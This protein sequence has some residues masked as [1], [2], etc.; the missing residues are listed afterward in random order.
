MSRAWNEAIQEFA[1]MTAAISAEALARA[2][3]LSEA[4]RK[5]MLAH[6]AEAEK[7]ARTPDQQALVF[8]LRRI[9]DAPVR[10]SASLL[11]D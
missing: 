8:S 10:A 2:G 11:L 1:A 9:L 7:V 4:D 6:L 3:L 5:T